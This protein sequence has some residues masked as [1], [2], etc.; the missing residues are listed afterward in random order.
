M[1][2]GVGVDSEAGEPETGGA[3]SCW[4]E[5]VAGDLSALGTHAG[6]HSILGP[7]SHCLSTTAGRLSGS[8]RAAPPI[9]GVSPA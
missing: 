6:C 3:G 5:V 7:G 8:T 9:R 1:V 2:V 4:L